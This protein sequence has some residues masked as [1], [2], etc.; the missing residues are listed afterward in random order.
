MRFRILS[1]LCLLAVLATPASAQRYSDS[2]LAEGFYRTV[3]GLEY[4]TFS[5]NARIVKRF[6]GPVRVYVDNRA[7]R[8]RRARVERFVRQVNREVRGLDI[9]VA[10]NPA[11]SNFTI[12][13]VDRWQYERIIQDEIYNSTRTAAPGRCMVRVVTGPRGISRAQA[14][15][16]S[17]EGEFLFNR[18][19][20]EETLQGLGPLNDDSTLTD[21][22]FND[23]SQLAEFTLH[24]RFILNM[25]YHP[26]IRPG[27]DRQTVNN[28]LSRVIADVRRWVR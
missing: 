15:I 14:V 21:S 13:V 1:A 10:S 22:V 2:A 17:D 4:A 5:A 12:Y 18:C 3:F 20:I 27:M 7:R 11:Q 25:L 9:A 16:V 23:S 19:L 24:D 28:I 26:D 6:I 8:D